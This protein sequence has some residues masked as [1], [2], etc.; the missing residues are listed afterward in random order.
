VTRISA[1]STWF[2]KYLFPIPFAGF[3]LASLWETVFL[4]PQPQMVPILLIAGALLVVIHRVALW[5]LADRVDEDGDQ[6]IVRRRGIEA[7]IPIADIV[8]VKEGHKLRGVTE[9]AL[10]LREPTPLGTKVVFA[11]PHT[12]NPFDAFRM[13][14]VTEQFHDRIRLNIIG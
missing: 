1:P 13:H 6:L 14:P 5:P 11:L 4:K 3:V 9:L 12:G 7:R 8:R 2:M 10:F